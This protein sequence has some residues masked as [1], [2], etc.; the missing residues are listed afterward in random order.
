VASD[1][2]IALVDLDAFY[3]AVE[4]LEHPAL[5]G[6]PL[7][8]GGRPESRGV[9]AAASYEARKYG[10]HSAMPMSKAIR[11][12]PDAII[13]K[14]RF[15][16]Y[17]DYSNQVMKILQRESDL[18]QQV[19][20]DEAYIDLTH[21]AQTMTEAEGLAHRMQGR[22][23]IEVG[24]PCSV[25]LARNRMVAKIACETG[26]PSGFVV[27]YPGTE[28]A[29][30]NPLDVSSMPGIGPQSTKR[31]KAH[32]YNT[33]G[34]IAAVRPQV[35]IG[36]LG[37]SGAALHQ[38]AM[39]EDPS[40]VRVERQ[41]KSISSEETF[42][43]DIDDRQVLIEQLQRA[44]SR[45]TDSLAKQGLVGRTV[46]LKLRTSDFTTLTRSVS[47]QNATAHS[48]AFYAD[49]LWL[50][51]KNWQPGRPVRLIGMEVSKLRPVQS[52]DQ[53]HMDELTEQL[54]VYEC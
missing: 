38:R 53:M 20:I 37:S 43:E 24:L 31:L 34:Q 49:V 9:V 7:L 16:L 50:L 14:P 35:L 27:I 26:K 6:K 41:P 15:P 30:L 11:V 36:I 3:A 54:E 28:P 52:P 19:S 23:R 51:D 47:R 4:V 44:V 46:T 33:L 12:C 39:G 29:F 32:G 8:I 21:V 10:C 13:M 22:V 42:P 1:R 45:V 2:R 40:P 25:G 17:R 18:V 5:A 48:K